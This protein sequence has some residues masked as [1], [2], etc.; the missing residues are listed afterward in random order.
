MGIGF[1][2]IVFQGLSFVGWLH[3]S[4]YGSSWK[5][6]RC[7]KQNVGGG[8]LVGTSLASMIRRRKVGLEELENLD[9]RLDYMLPSMNR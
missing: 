1:V 6:Y 8:V 7:G 4:R 5:V 2:Y 3:A 9:L